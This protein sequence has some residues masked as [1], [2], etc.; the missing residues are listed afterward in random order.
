MSS[1]K[2]S[3]QYHDLAQK[4]QVE[5]RRLAAKLVL[6]HLGSKA[7][8]AG[9][10]FHGYDSIAA[11]CSIARSRVAPALKYLRDDLKV[12][13]WERGTGGPKQQD[14]NRYTL[15]LTAMKRLVAKQGVFDAVTGKL[16]RDSVEAR[17]ETEV[18]S[19]K[20][21]GLK[22]QSS[23]LK[24]S[25]E[26]LEQVGQSPVE[27][28]ERTG[29]ESRQRSVA[30]SVNPQGKSNPHGNPQGMGPGGVSSSSGQNGQ[31]SVRDDHEAAFKRAMAKRQADI[32]ARL[33]RGA[34]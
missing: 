20:Q 26:S 27:S 28:P 31:G 12:V 13:S 10:S 23:P 32:S 6:L 18:E 3:W 1:R 7:N 14:T 9:E 15:N 19:G 4:I 34:K 29:V 22:G 33:Q 25:V 5:S 17:Q 2:L 24:H 16:L 21:T 30:P 11:H 8:D